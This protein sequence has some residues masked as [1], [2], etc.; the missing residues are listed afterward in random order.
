MYNI[1]IWCGHTKQFRDFRSIYITYHNAHS[2]PTKDARPVATHIYNSSRIPSI[3]RIVHGMCI[4]SLPRR[5]CLSVAVY[6]RHMDWTHHVAIIRP[7]APLP[8]PRMGR[9]PRERCDRAY[10][11]GGGWMVDV[12]DWTTGLGAWCVMVTNECR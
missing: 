6:A 5:Q 11:V 2:T 10:V 1:S 12:V 4:S 8:C 7:N 9:V 3:D